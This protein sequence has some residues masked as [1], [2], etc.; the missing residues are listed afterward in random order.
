M[1]DHINDQGQKEGHEPHQLDEWLFSFQ[2]RKFENYY[3]EIKMYIHP[4][5][6]SRKDGHLFTPKYYCVM[7]FCG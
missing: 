5:E 3:Q 7:Y 6:E 4:Q 2:A 1:K